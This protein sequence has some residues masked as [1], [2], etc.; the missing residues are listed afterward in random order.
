MADDQRIEAPPLGELAAPEDPFELR[1]PSGQAAPYTS[2]LSPTDSVLDS[3]G[4][5]EN[6]KIYRELLRDDQVEAAW[7]QRRLALTSCD[8]IVEP[9]ADDPL[10]K[11]AAEEL[12]RELKSLMWD[13]ITDKQLYSVFYGWGVAEI[14]WKPST[15][16]RVS[17]SFDRV[18]V[19]DRGRF[20]FG[21]RGEIYL[22][23]SGAGWVQMPDRKFWK[24]AAGAE[25][26]DEPYG[27]G[28]AH[29]L[30]WP[31]WFKRNDIKYWLIFL[32]KFGM[33]TAIAKL[34]PGTATGDDPDSIA[35]RKKALA[36]LRN[37]A[38]D[39]GVLVPETIGVELLEAAR[40]GAAD[41]KSMHDAM[42][43]AIS[44]II[45]GQ[46]ATTE[47]TPGR[48]G[49]DK[50]QEGVAQKIVEADAD[51]LCDTFNNGPVKWW[52][53]WNFPGAVPPRVF[54]QTEPTEDLN[55]RA[56][57]DNKISSLGY[58]PSEDYI[59]STYGDGWTKKQAPAVSPIVLP[60]QAVRQNPGNADPAQ[61]AE[62]EIAA[63]QTIKAGRRGDQ[64]ALV[65]AAREFAGQWDTVTGQRVR[66]VLQAAEFAEDYETMRA[67]LNEILAEVPPA[68]TRQALGR[69]GFFAQ[70]MGALRAQR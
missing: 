62:G 20:R 26:H 55:A 2:L 47:G 29:R 12:D 68:E 24:V 28:L 35:Q 41:Y 8:S 9:G 21:R 46:T 59:K 11:R 13:D 16:P 39:A 15:T 4:G 57:R 45:I 37:I 65:E 51:L 31:V 36:M 7:S 67:R 25:N 38:T 40:S 43:A 19:R 6:L 54:R 63:L 66:Q 10:S 49:S 64:Q 61:F 56:E 18:V 33:P 58:E 69:A 32:E 50:T 42:N 52:T 53:E 60:G 17:V 3:K 44:K 14:I 23:E 1:R 22:W 48:L 5:I 70:L 27:L 30:Y 34:P